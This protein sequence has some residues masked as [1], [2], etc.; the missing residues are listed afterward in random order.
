M[1]N[2]EEKERRERRKEV[3]NQTMEEGWMEEDVMKGIRRKK[4]RRESALE[5]EKARMGLEGENLLLHTHLRETTEKQREFYSTMETENQ[6]ERAVLK[7]Q[8]CV[9]ISKR[10]NTAK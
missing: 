6:F 4:R 9:I 3:R 8:M 2:E 5:P 10:I 1:S 7:F